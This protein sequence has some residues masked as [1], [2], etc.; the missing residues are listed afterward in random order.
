MRIPRFYQP[1]PLTVGQTLALSAVNHRHAIQ[2][3]RLKASETLI[4][5]NGEGGEYHA[6]L[7]E[8]T[9]KYATIKLQSHDTINRE[10]PLHIT[11]ALALIKP[12]KMDFA[13]Q[14][15]VELGISAIQPLITDRS[16]IRIK[17]AQLEKKMNRW[18]GI[19]KGACEQS[20]RTR[21]PNIFEPL[22][23]S[24]Y[25]QHD[26][27]ALRLTMLPTAKQTLHDISKPAQA[28]ELVIGP[29]GG[30]TDSEEALLQE[31]NT[32]SISF[33]PRILRAE[34]AALAGLATIQAAWGGLI[35]S[36]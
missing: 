31:A 18:Q 22:S 36:R 8:V 4:I 17:V 7:E 30:F 1:E 23:L 13:L 32:T 15:A 24:N 12:E 11:L 26:S 6:Q 3:L 5:F 2:V 16:I 35:D 19:I 14:K 21:V 27:S 29:E 9:K 10:S 20:G 33:G 25:L 34:T 28:I